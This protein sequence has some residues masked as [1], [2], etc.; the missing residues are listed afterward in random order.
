MRRTSP[1]R[2]R[3]GLFRGLLAPPSPAAV[4]GFAL[5]PLAR[6]LFVVSV[7]AALAVPGVRRIQI[8]LRT[9]AVIKDLRGFAADFQRYAHERGDWPGLSSPPGV[10][11]PGAEKYL[12]ASPWKKPSPI[13]GAYTWAAFSLHQGERY[14]AAIIISH[15]AENRV[16]NLRQQLDDLDRQLDDGNLATGKFRLGYR[17]QPVFV[18][19]H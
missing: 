11:P 16:T 2:L 4:A 6:A 14:R 1:A 7:L 13:G 8:H 15:L 10:I 18:L 9:G 19:E 17:N 12:A 5:L 3:I